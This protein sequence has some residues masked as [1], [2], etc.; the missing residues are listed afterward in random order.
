MA[1]K[2]SRTKIGAVAQKAERL[3][4]DIAELSQSPTLMRFAG[5]A[6]TD[7][8][9][10]DLHETLRAFAA[11]LNLCLERPSQS[12]QP[13]RW[14]AGTLDLLERLRMDMTGGIAPCAVPGK[15]R[16]ALPI[17]NCFRH[18]GARRIAG[19]QE[20]NVEMPWCWY[21]IARQRHAWLCGTH[22]WNQSSQPQLA[23]NV[24]IAKSRI[25]IF[26]SL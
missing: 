20:Q 11:E 25:F 21:H 9:F 6:L 17:Q 26:P 3:A 1:R 8:R 5:Q 24:E 10:A 16:E 13:G 2:E 15:I 4:R 12:G 22:A 14:Y 23:N 18:D 7:A 19:A